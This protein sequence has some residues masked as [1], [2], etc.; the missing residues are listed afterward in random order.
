MKQ[1]CIQENESITYIMAHTNLQHSIGATDFCT[2]SYGIRYSNERFNP[3]FTF[4]CDIMIKDI[5]ELAKIDLTLS[6]HRMKEGGKHVI[7][8]KGSAYFTPKQAKN[9]FVT[10]DNDDEIED[11]F[12]SEA[13]HRIMKKNIH[14]TMHNFHLV[15]CIKRK[16]FHALTAFIKRMYQRS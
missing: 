10:I 15:K 4:A 7:F 14:G 5:V 13:G 9:L 6:K 8:L 2:L 16:F 1:S 3:I 11:F 12:A